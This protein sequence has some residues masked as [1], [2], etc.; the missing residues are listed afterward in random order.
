LRSITQALPQAT[1]GDNVGLNIKGVS[2]KEVKRGFVTGDSKQDSPAKAETFVAQVIMMSHTGQISNG[3][4]PV[5]DCHTSHIASK[6]KEIQSKI[7]SRTNKVQEETRKFIKTGCSA[8]VEILPSEPMVVETFTD[9]PPLGRL[10]VRDM[11]STVAVGVIRLV[12]KKTKDS[13][14]TKAAEKGGKKEEGWTVLVWEG[15]GG[16]V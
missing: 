1:P 12:V 15:G 6:F 5:L 11:R 10:T 7:D 3:Y 13:K 4:T 2:V 16:V 14:A 8:L 9:Y